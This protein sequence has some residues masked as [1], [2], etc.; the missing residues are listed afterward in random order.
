[1]KVKK[2]IETEVILTQP[3]SNFIIGREQ[4]KDLRFENAYNEHNISIGMLPLAPY[5]TSGRNVCPHAGNCVDICI[6]DSWGKIRYGARIKRSLI[7]EYKPEIFFEELIREIVNFTNNNENPVIRLNGFSDITW[8]TENF[9]YSENIAR[10]FKKFKR[11]QYSNDILKKYINA[12]ESNLFFINTEVTLLELFSDLIFYDYTKFTNRKTP[13]NYYLTYSY[14]KQN[15]KVIEHS[16]IAVIVSVSLKEYL[17]KNSQEIY[18]N[19]KIMIVD[20]DF[21]DCRIIDNEKNLP[22]KIYAL[23]AF[24]QDN[25]DKKLESDYAITSLDEFNKVFEVEF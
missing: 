6:G 21:Q 3:I 13:K 25:K 1:M 16:S 5:D 8:E 2:N 10:I 23:L 24:Q 9:I 17:L 4:Q 12:Q 20:A 22:T 11:P 14:D 15:N 7:H 18:E 19:F